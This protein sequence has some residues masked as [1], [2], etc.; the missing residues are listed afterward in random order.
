MAKYRKVETRIWGDVKFRALHDDSKLAFLLLLTHP[1]MTSLGAVRISFESLATELGWPF[2]RIKASLSEVFRKGMAKPDLEA[3]VIWLPNFIRYNHPEAPN[4]VLSWQ[5]A[6]ESLPECEI[7]SLALATALDYCETL[8][9]P[10]RKA[11]ERL[12]ACLSKGK[13][14]AFRIPEQEQEP[15]QEPT[16]Q[17]KRRGEVHGLEQS[18]LSIL[19]AKGDHAIVRRVAWCVSSGLISQASA[20]SAANGVRTAERRPRNPVG[21]FVKILKN[22]ISDFDEL[23]SRAPMNGDL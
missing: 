16:D 3:H 6:Y 9:E 2:E 21:Y 13:G 23:L 1:H 8:S 10:F 22:E 18:L 19:K 17:I 4:V 12:R 7:A 20:F 11:S 15:E 5:T 14:H